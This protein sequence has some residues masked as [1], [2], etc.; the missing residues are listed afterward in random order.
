MRYLV[1]LLLVACGDD[2]EKVDRPDPV[3]PT[4]EDCQASG[5]LVIVGTNRLAYD[6]PRTQTC[7]IH[8]NSDCMQ[9]CSRSM[10]EQWAD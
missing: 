1:A 5:C 8:G 2:I 3:M 10:C 7:G 6:P 4:R 9:W